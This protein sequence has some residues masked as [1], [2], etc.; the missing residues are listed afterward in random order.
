MNFNITEEL[1]SME[2]LKNTTTSQDIFDSVLDCLKNSNLCLKKLI[3]IT[4]D[5][6]PA[7][8]GKNNG[9][10]K[11]IKNKVLESTLNYDL[12]SFH[13]IIHQQSLCKHKF[14]FKNVSDVII[15][16]VNIIKSKALNHRQFCSFLQ[17]FKS[18]YIDVIYYSSV[19]WLS[20]GKMLKRVWDLKEEIDICLEIKDLLCEFK[21]KIKQHEWVCDFA[22]VTDIMLK[23]ND[24]NIIL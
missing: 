7:L 4:T 14:P 23:L 11:L 22:F 16:V 5:G 21:V 17:E 18:D 6:A 3:S 9:F 24:L 20:I 10:V 2:S 1:L 19:R 15:E 13:C 12:M 8:I